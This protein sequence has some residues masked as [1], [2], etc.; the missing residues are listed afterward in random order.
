MNQI[1][2][3]LVQ[4]TVQLVAASHSDQV[5]RKSEFMCV[6]APKLGN[7]KWVM[8]TVGEFMSGHWVELL[9][10]SSAAATSDRLG[11]YVIKYKI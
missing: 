7:N 8:L 10:M 3:L 1:M 11:N 9:S 6:R 2:S 4:R 5:H